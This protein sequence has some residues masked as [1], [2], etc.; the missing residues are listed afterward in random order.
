M[1]MEKVISY[2]NT[3]RGNG[4]KESL[5]RLRL[6]LAKLGNPQNGLSYIHITG[7]NGKGSTA[8]MFQ[9]VLREAGLNVGLFTSPHLE[10]VNERI[11]LNNEYIKDEDFIRLVNQME[12]AV[13]ELEAALG[14]KFYAFELMTT[15]AFL[16]F[17]EQQPD[18]VILEAGIGGRLDSTNV[19]ETP[20]VAVITS[21]G[22]DHTSTLGTSKQA[23]MNEKIQILKNQ[24]HIVIGPVADSLKTI[25]SAWAEKVH[26]EITFLEASNL[27]LK[28][29]G[30]EAQIFSYKDFDDV[31]LPFIGKH[32]IENAGLVL[33]ACL[34][35][36]KKGYP[37]NKE[38]IV[39]GLA[40]AVWPGRFELVLGEPQFYMDGAH[41]VAG[42]ARLVE[43]VEDVFAR[44]KI[45][46]VVGM[47]KDKEY[48]KMLDQ[49]MHL[50]AEFV[51][52]SPDEY[53]GFDPQAVA[54]MISAQ[55]VRARVA[56]DAD[57]ILQFVRTEVPKD[58]VVIQ[59]GSLYLVGAMK[60]AL[61]RAGLE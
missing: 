49:V 6:L 52:V 60:E 23:I 47:M 4:Q 1:T 57:E 39:A 10:V 43:T 51:F 7:T 37:L 12:P 9:A 22:I 55:G 40:K 16:Y 14:Q 17:Q 18:L 15:V 48:E 59:F 54:K 25:A 28:E 32:Q 30:K 27:Q 31:H 29:V 35:L 19:I 2:V 45:Y 34:I 13:L 24:G 50:A 20:D 3:N 46:F 41:N 11:R 38:V 44:R 61:S 58:A 8:A 26:G 5:E 21:I 42:V 33:E 53:R 56:A 36:Q